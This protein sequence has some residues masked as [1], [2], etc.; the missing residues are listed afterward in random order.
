MIQIRKDEFIYIKKIY[1][2][3]CVKTVNRFYM[4]ETRECLKALKEFND[5]KG[6]KDND[7]SE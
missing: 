4:A 2:Q 7:S 1:P 5:L 6:K 3:D